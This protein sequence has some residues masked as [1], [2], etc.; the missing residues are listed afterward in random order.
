MHLSIHAAASEIRSKKLS[1]PDLLESVP[2]PAKLLD[3]G[4]VACV[5]EVEQESDPPEQLR[6]IGHDR[7]F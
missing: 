7:P 6:M 2:Q 3:L 1:P 5:G 4:K